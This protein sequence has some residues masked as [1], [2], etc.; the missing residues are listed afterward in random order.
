[1]NKELTLIARFVA[2][3]SA[4]VFVALMAL[5]IIAFATQRQFL[6]AEPYTEA[7][8]QVNAY[9]RAPGILANLF[10]SRL[11]GAP[12]ELARQL[13]VPDVSQSDAELFL[14]V[15]LPRDWLQEQT[16]VAVEH[17]VAKLNGETAAQPAVISMAG[18]KEQL[19]SAAGRQALLAVIETRPACGATD[20]GA[21]TC[22][23]NLAGDISC[24]PP[25]LNLEL[26]GAAIDLATGSIA[27]LIPD[28]VDLD[29][30]LRPMAPLTAPLGNLARRY[31]SII[32]FLA[33]Y[34]WL[35]ALPFL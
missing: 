33:R 34:G 16:E 19:N 29:A 27:A 13:P 25:S 26:C 22:G 17:F 23:F 6:R 20:L 30:T 31:V 3:M 35:L 28:Q 9:E 4:L 21:F 10:L 7:L 24:R 14:T 15:L 32:T 1:M 18:L 12:N 11:D 5:S 8:L 2:L